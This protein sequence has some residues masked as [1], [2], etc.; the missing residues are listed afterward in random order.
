MHIVDRVV[1]GGVV[2]LVQMSEVRY[3]TDVKR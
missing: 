3:F 1:I 2:V